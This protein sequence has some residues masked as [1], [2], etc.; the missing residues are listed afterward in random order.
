M[1]YDCCTSCRPTYL[2]RHVILQPWPAS[3]DCRISGTRYEVTWLRAKQ[4]WNE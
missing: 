4:Y 1:F 2:K 3:F